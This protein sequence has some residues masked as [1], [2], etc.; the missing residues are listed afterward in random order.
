MKELQVFKNSEFGEL[1]VVKIEGR[2]Y[3]PATDCAK[4]LGYAK[5]HNAIEQHC[6]YSLKQGVPHPQNPNKEI[7]MNFIPEGDLYRLIVKSKLPSAEKFERWV[8]DEVLP[9]VRKT[10]GY[11]ANE[12]MFINTYL[13]YADETTK[14]LFK[15][16]LE[17]V[18]KQNELIEFQKKEIEYKED[19]IIGLVDNVDLAVKRQRLQDIIKKGYKNPQ[20]IAQRWNLL[21]KEFEQKYH[22]DINRRLQGESVKVIKPKIKNKIDYIDRVMDKIPEL[23]ELAC[24]LYENDVEKLKSEWFDTVERAG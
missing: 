3:F 14:L 22:V 24:K 20:H 13:P 1:S 15:T 8:F 2:E 19:V 10:G 11:V 5:P 9:T 7:E 21:Y 4:M 16:T 6:R 18:R 17:T 23:Y 12:N